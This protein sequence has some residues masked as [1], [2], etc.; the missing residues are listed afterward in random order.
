MSTITY[1]TTSSTT[2]LY[3]FKTKINF[4]GR[5]YTILPKVIGFASTQGRDGIVKVSSP[6]IGKIDLIER[7][8]D[9][10]DYPTDPTLLPF[11]SVPAIVDISGISRI[12]EIQVTDGGVRY[13]Q[14]PSLTVRGNSNVQIAAHIEGGSVSRVEIIKNVFEFKKL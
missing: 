7:I 13:N 6:D 12:N 11:L 8:K 5:G 2:E 3:Y 1:S 9:G 10:F 14:P 4:P